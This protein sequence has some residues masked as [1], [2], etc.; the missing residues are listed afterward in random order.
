ML[1]I[2]R[3]P[4]GERFRERVRE[5]GGEQSRELKGERLLRPKRRRRLRAM[6]RFDVAM[7]VMAWVPRYSFVTT[8]RHERW[9]RWVPA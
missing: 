1:G 2:R 8:E 4:S 9:R 3:A 5:Q 6:G 7:P